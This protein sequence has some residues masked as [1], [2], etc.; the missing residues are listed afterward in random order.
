MSGCGFQYGVVVC[1]GFTNLG[2]VATVWLG[3]IANGGS[4][5]STIR[6]G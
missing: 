5:S 1:L 6:E 3:S 2:F 4:S